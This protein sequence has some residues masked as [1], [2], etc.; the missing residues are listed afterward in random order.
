M[1]APVLTF[2]E[3][4]PQAGQL[5]PDHVLPPDPAAGAALIFALDSRY[6]WR[7][8]SV[9]FLLSTDANVANRF[10]SVDYCDPEGT[11][12]VR[13]PALAVQAAGVA[14]QEYDFSQRALAVSG[15][16]GQ[17]QFASLI[18]AWIPGGWQL[19]VNVGN[20][21][22]GDTIKTTRLYVEKFEAIA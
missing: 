3:G 9:R 16:A 20:V 11:A 15:I 5:F 4:L 19:R 6:M 14:N 22:V 17:P 12:W 10:A 2:E 8:V 1:T 13:N 18:R 7:P 21:Q